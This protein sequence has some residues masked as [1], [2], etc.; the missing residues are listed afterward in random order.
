MSVYALL[1]C[2]RLPR[3]QEWQPAIAPIML[4]LGASIP[5]T[6]TLILMK[7][8]AMM[9][10]VSAGRQSQLAH[11]YFW[12]AAVTPV[13]TT[14]VWTSAMQH[15]LKNF[16]SIVILPLLHI[17]Y[18]AVGVLC[19]VVF[20]QEY[21]QMSVTAIVM[22]VV[23][24]LG[25]FGGIMLSLSPDALVAGLQEMKDQAAADESLTGVSDSSMHITVAAMGKQCLKLT[26]RR[27]SIM[28]R[29]PDRIQ[30]QSDSPLAFVT[31]FWQWIM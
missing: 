13:A 22:Y 28:Y 29:N 10:V 3:L 8:L 27:C 21:R 16:P 4:A 17:M 18:T 30:A 19:G 2:G 11:W 15:G 1:R 5:G 14:S 31:L 12:V 25:M 26:P 7:A 23:G 6:Q 20:F 9:I 24:F